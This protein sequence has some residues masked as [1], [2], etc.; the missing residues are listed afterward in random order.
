MTNHALIP[1]Q[2]VG[3]KPYAGTIR[4]TPLCLGTLQPNL[5]IQAPM[6]G[7]GGGGGGLFKRLHET[8]KIVVGDT[9]RQIHQDNNIK[10]RLH[11]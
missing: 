10:A 6:R 5:S 2:T 8:V 7:G 1:Q 4:L 9:T 3:Y 11:E